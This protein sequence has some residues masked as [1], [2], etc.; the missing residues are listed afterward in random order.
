MPT[1]DKI[2]DELGNA[3]LFSKLDLQQGFHQILMDEANIP[4]IAF[5]THQGHYEYKVMPFGQCNNSSTFQATMNEL[6]KPFL[7]KFAVVFFDDVLIYG[8]NLDAHLSHLESV[9]QVLL[10][11]QFSL[12][13]SKCILAQRQCE[14]IGHIMSQ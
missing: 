9:F 6:L 1:I 14:Y 8:S 2:L 13:G 7:Y 12:K 11:D 4:K 10:N 5:H 3:S